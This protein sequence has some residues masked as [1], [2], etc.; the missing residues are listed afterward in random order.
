[1]RYVVT[2]P[3]YTPS[4]FPDASAQGSA[5]LSGSVGVRR[6]LVPAA[7]RA[8]A[9]RLVGSPRVLQLSLDLVGV[10]FSLLAFMHTPLSAE[11]LFHGVFVV[12]TLHAFLFGLRGTLLR[13]GI[14]SLPLLVYANA[15]LIGLTEDQLE[16]SE[17][18]LMFVIA[19]IVASMADQRKKTSRLYAARFRQASERLLTVQE[20]ERRRIASELHDGVG[21]VLTALTLTL[22][23][24]RA[25]PRLAT[26]VEHVKFAR[27]LSDTALAE[28]R[29]LSHS[30]RPVRSEERG[31]VPALRDL[32]SQSGFP[33]EVVA[34]AA[35]AEPRVLWPTATVEVYRIVQEALANAARHS[36]SERAQVS[37]SLEGE[38]LTVVVRDEGVGFSPGEQPEPGIGIAGMEERA[39]LLGGALR[40]ETAP[41]QGTRVVLSVPTI[42]TGRVIA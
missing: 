33:V 28:T 23:A 21:Q 8:T 14:A 12:L 35:A 31:L 2:T 11:F 18:P 6:G 17:W 39:A 1:M 42:A 7:V 9:A 29:H 16:L 13:I 40:I 32:A 22:D 27:Q 30:M 37:V 25:A 36:G 20:E 19:T 5:G 3:A 24:A 10:A 34:D 15:H 41:G 38:R 26:A 4:A